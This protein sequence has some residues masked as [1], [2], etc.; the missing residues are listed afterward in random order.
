M[1]NHVMEW[2]K[3]HPTE[4]LL[5]VGA[6][7]GVF[8]LFSRSSSGGGNT[9]ASAYYGAQAQV[10]GQQ[11]S[12]AAVE[13]QQQAQVQQTQIAA[14]TQNYQ[15]LASLAAIK[16][17]YDAAVRAAQI[18]ANVANNTTNAQAGVASQYI[19]A[20]TSALQSELTAAT[21][22]QQQKLNFMQQFAQYVTT[23]NGSQNRLSFLQS[24]LGQPNAAAATQQSYANV[25]GSGNAMWASIV[26]S[27]GTTMTGLFG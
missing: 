9:S 19:N 11:A 16:T 24:V 17:Q 20:E 18:Q 6:V 4:A 7:I 5:G 3:N 10:A 27:I 25:T 12:Y 13:A 22:A 1:S 23:F 14:D 8:Y 21:T 26:N 2:A 15:T